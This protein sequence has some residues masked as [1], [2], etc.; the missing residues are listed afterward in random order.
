MSDLTLRVKGWSF[1]LEIVLLFLLGGK[2]ALA[3]TPSISSIRI[4]THGGPSIALVS[5]G[6][7][8]VIYGSNLT[9]SQTA[10]QPSTLP[11]PT[12][13]CNSQ[14][15]INS[16]PAP[17]YIVSL[18]AIYFQVPFGLPTGPAVA[19]VVNQT[20]Q[21]PSF[22]FQL[23]AFSPGIQALQDPN[24]STLVST[25][26]P[27]AVGEPLELQCVGLGPTNPAVAAGAAPPAN[28]LAVTVNQPIVLIDGS[29]QA[30]V[31]LSVLDPNGPG[32]YE[33]YFAVP[34][35][36]PGNHMLLIQIGGI[37]S[38]AVELPVAGP[39]PPSIYPGAVVPLN[40]TTA[41][42]EPGEWVSIFGTNLASSTTTWTGNFPT[43]LGGASVTINGK[44]AYLAFVS[45]SQI[46]VQAPDDTT[47]GT[48]PVVVTTDAG[49][50]TSMV[51]LAP[52]GPSFFLLDTKHVAG[53][54]LR[55][56]G[57]GAYGG[58]SYDILGPTGTSLGYPTVAAKAGDVVELFGTGLGPTNPTVPAGQAFSRAAPT[59]NAVTLHI[60]SVS[61]AQTF[62]GL[63]G[64]GLDQINLT[65]PEG[66]GTGDAPLQAFVGG[67]QTPSGVVI[68]LQ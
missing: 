1:W 47:T 3:Q 65:V 20:T 32:I 46:N 66:L 67:V 28:P 44:A 4:D 25:S 37:S 36:S 51:T 15:L 8:A 18:G 52:F 54:I 5:P 19:V 40:S 38:A 9:S 16:I 13:L 43:S 23:S 24:N 12:T 34:E 50:A 11:L 26:K 6:S 61:V 68:S 63:S 64:A 22:A 7:L 60:N 21:S 31:S 33:V 29:I 27:A 62:A 39:Q 49:S 57:S 55:S 59:T 53:I 56:D 58:G 10:C 41:T 14:V 45:F 42:I 35:L 30:T 17:V 2:I 48:V